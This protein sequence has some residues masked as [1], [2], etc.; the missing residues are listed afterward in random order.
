VPIIAMTANAFESD[1]QACFEAGMNDFLSKPVTPKTLHAMLDKWLNEISKKQAPPSPPA[2]PVRPALVDLPGLDVSR[3][4]ARVRGNQAFYIE[5]LQRL[6]QQYKDYAP[7]IQKHLA[8]GDTQDALDL[9]LSLQGAASTL[10]ANTLS[11]LLSEAASKLT[12]GTHGIEQELQ[13]VRSVFETLDATLQPR[14]D[15][16]HQNSQKD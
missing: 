6:L 13:A 12:T 8:N 4:L 9:V 5:L 3:G 1:R 10:G 15:A 11:T 2:T 7:R 16:L 14:A